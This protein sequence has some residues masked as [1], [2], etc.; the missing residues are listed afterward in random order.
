MAPMERLTMALRLIFFKEIN[1]RIMDTHII[2]QTYITM[3]TE[4]II[5]C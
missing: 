3:V 2:L 5:N 1:N 4:L